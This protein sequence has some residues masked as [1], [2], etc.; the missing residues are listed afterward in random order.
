MG[1]RSRSGNGPRRREGDGC[2]CDGRFGHGLSGRD[3]LLGDRSRYRCGHG[4]GAARNEIGVVLT[5][6]GK[7]V[8]RRVAHAEDLIVVVLCGRH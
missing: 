3:G 5:G 8:F 2:G 4:L 1:R 6:V 7:G